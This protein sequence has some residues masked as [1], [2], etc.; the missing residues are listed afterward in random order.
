MV[1]VFELP[2]SAAEEANKHR[3]SVT[4][5]GPA[6]ASRQVP[7]NDQTEVWKQLSRLGRLRSEAHAA[8]AFL[9]VVFDLETLELVF[10]EASHDVG[11]HLSE[12]IELR[13]I[14]ELVLL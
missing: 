2:P 4:S 6:E 1:K 7:L 8:G 10:V 13:F 11:E 14:G 12:T 3:S 5:E 9:E